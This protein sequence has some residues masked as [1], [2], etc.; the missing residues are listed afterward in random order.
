MMEHQFRNRTLAQQYVG[1]RLKGNTKL[2]RQDLFAYYQQHKKDYEVKPRVKWQ[3]ILISRN[4]EQ[5]ARAKLQA[6]VDGLKN[7]RDF[8]ELAAE[9]SDG[10]TAEDKG[11][12]DWTNKGSLADS[13]IEELLFKLPVGEPSELLT[14]SPSFQVVRVIE[15]KDGGH[16]P[17]DEV[18]DQ[19]REQILESGNKSEITTI[20]DELWQTATI[21]TK[22][23][24]DETK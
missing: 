16:V 13:R 17:F 22:Y 14:T 15:R 11:V 5:K 3:Q 8:G 21:D 19:I 6:L 12:Y 7:N 23:K 10:P 4:D 9:I 1:T 2:S 24:F 20:V 18:Q